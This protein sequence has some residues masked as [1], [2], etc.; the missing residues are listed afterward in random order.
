MDWESTAIKGDKAVEL[1]GACPNIHADTT[2]MP[3]K[4]N[5]HP[6]SSLWL[7]YII[8]IPDHSATEC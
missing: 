2:V 3:E 6:S 5:K 4:H 7:F 1:R 8:V